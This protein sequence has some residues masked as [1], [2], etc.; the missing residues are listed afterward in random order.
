MCLFHAD[1]A[2]LILES[3]MY[4]RTPFRLFLRSFFTEA[5]RRAPVRT[6]GRRSAYFFTEFFYRGATAS[7]C[8]P[9]PGITIPNEKP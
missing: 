1:Y 2:D 7:A 4:R 3:A 9:S 5:L 8:T 6:G